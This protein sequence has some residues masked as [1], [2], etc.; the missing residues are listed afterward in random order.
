MSYSGSAAHSVSYIYDADGNRTQMVD[1][2]GTSTST[3]DAF[4]E[5]AT[6]ESGAGTTT[7]Y[8]YDSFADV[9]SVQWPL[10]SGDFWSAARFT[11]EFDNAGQLVEVGG[12]TV[13][14]DYFTNT[15]DGLPATVVLGGSGDTL[16]TTYDATDSP[17]S[18]TLTDGTSTL[19]EFAYSDTPSGAIASETDTPT[20]SL[21]PADYTYDAQSRVTAMTPG[22]SGTLSY[23][24]DASANPTT[25]PS[26]ATGTYDD[27][28]ELTSS[29]L[30]GTTSTYGYDADGERTSVSGGATVTATYNGAEE[31]TSY[32]NSAADTSSATYDGDGLR[33]SVTTTPSG[34]D[35]STNAMSW[36]TSGSVPVVLTDSTYLYTYGDGNTPIVET[37]RTTGVSRFLI[38]DALGS[39]RGILTTSGSLTATTSYDAYGNPETTGGLTGY[40]PFGFAG[41]YT[42]STGLVYLVNRYYDPGTAQFITVDPTINRTDQAYEYT[43][44]DP[45]NS[46]DPLG[47]IVTGPPGS[48]GR[49]DL[50]LWIAHSFGDA[51]YLPR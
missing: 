18:I 50:K 14:I 29:V 16:D 1:G 11:R 51:T 25:L 8:G 36:D 3:Y 7:Q 13:A 10:Q 21:S 23:G 30:S 43:G 45:V 40:T 2:S 32:D 17:S 6:V 19:Q 37:N 20:S 47:L 22:T 28:S 27:A 26:G 24:Y 33:T 15:A 31:V 5:L 35:S 34:G 39:V 38:S 49:Y 41:G 48:C 46:I 4:D 42:D 9:D 44:D 12:P